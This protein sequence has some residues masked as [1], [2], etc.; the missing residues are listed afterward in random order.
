MPNVKEINIGSL[1]KHPCCE[2]GLDHLDWVNL[3]QINNIVM[4]EWELMRDNATLDG[5]ALSECS[6]IF[7]WA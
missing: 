3:D 2:K 4:E 6:D 1:I 7:G 5:Y